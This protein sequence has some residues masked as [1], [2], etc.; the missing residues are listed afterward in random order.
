MRR[1]ILGCAIVAA[2]IYAAIALPAAPIKG[3]ATLTATA[4]DQQVVLSWP[5]SASSGVTGYRVYRRGTN[6]K[7]PTSPLATTGALTYT[8]TG[9]A[10][11][12]AYT[13]RVTAVA[14]SRESK[15]SPTATATP[16]AVR[17]L[18]ATLLA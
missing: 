4:G 2:L 18:R 1:L 17:V 3:P 16:V 7:W 14:G 5:A 8:N 10:N 12:T 6:G 11:G 9:L 13:Y 15:P